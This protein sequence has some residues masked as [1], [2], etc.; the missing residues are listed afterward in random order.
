MYD[1]NVGF[2]YYDINYVWDYT[3]VYPGW[4]LSSGYQSLYNLS[5]FLTHKVTLVDFVD[6]D[7]LD[8]DVILG[9]NLLHYVQHYGK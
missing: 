2:T 9:M 6:L 3:Y 5:Y 1:F 8:F 7:M 4:W